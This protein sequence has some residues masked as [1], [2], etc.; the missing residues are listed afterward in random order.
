[1]F[2]AILAGGQG[3]RLG[4]VEK[5]LL[6]IGGKRVIEYVLHALEDFERV[7]VCR[8]E[9]QSLLYSR[10]A[11]T[12]TDILKGLGPL[13]GIHSALLYFNKPVLIVSSD[14]PFL[15]PRV[16]K[17]IYRECWNADAVIPRW[18]DGKLEPTFAAYSTKLIPEI[19][20]CFELGEKKVIKAIE[21]LRKVKFYPVEKL[22]PYDERLLTFFNVNTPQDLNR[23]EEIRKK[24]CLAWEEMGEGEFHA[25]G[26][27]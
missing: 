24:L 1:V 15:N 25:E 5:G 20:R 22:K 13:S 10:Y 18:E 26:Q 11:P 19:E 14:M 2:A 6:K 7:I 27:I 12:I 17:V 4:G 3:S 8:D 21:K 23:A 9:G 16:C